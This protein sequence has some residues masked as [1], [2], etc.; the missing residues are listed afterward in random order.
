MIFVNFLIHKNV[1]INLLSGEYNNQI[2]TPLYYA[3]RNNNLNIVKLL[4]NGYNI[5]LSNDYYCEKI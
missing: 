1:K 5:H 3:I 2:H 4:D